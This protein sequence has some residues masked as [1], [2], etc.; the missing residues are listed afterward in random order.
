MLFIMFANLLFANSVRI[1]ATSFDE[2]KYIFSTKLYDYE[3]ISL[4]H[5]CKTFGDAIKIDYDEWTVKTIINGKK[6]TFYGGSSFYKIDGEIYHFPASTERIGNG[7]YIPL[8]EFIR[9]IKIHFYEKLEYEKE[10]DTYILSP[11]EY[12]LGKIKIKSLKNGTI[13]KIEADKVFEKKYC[14]IWQTSNWIY[15]TIYG[16]NIDIEK[17]KG[18]YSHGDVKEIDAIQTE[19]SV[20]LSF[21]L[22]HS[23]SG[24]E[25]SI[26]EVKNTI[27][28][29]VR[30]KVT[31]TSAEAIKNN[32][33]MREKWLIDTIVLD[34]GHGGKDPGTN[35]GRLKEKDIVLD[36]VLELGRLL[37][38]YLDV[39]VVYTRKTDRFIPLWQRTKIAN[40][41]NGKLFVSVHVNA[42]EDSRATYGTETYLLAPRGTERAIKIAAQENKVIKL[43]QNQDRYSKM[44]SPQQYI[45]ATMAQRE[46]MKESE[47]LAKYVENEYSSRISS[48]SRGLRQAGFIVLIGASMPSILT[49]VGF[50]TNKNERINLS[51][52]SYRK[53]IALSLYYAIKR[54]K[55]EQDN[56]TKN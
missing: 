26:D 7:I 23:I 50:I 46:F 38:K 1:R 18:K 12:S 47:D 40:E 51:Q 28:I 55:I 44:L 49:E 20:Q 14:K 13:I 41:N 27:S 33:D 45:L 17:T 2:T 4:T 36:I 25:F 6:I 34:A 54:F 24:Y 31:Q 37:E 3:W 5:F 56:K 22:R 11:A 16:A 15:F 8:A 30:K 9:I 29:S 19:E 21:K 53:K 35:Y 42:I 52:H 32:K 10:I 48:K 39:K 43:E